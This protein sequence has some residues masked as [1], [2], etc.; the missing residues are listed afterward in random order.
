MSLKAGTKAPEFT[1]KI[2]GKN[3]FK[4]SEQTGKW[5]VLYFYPKDDTPGCTMEA[6]DFRDNMERLTSLGA[7]VVGVSPDSENSH[8]RFKSKYNLNFVL[9]PDSDNEICKLYDILGEKS[10]F[11]KKYI[12][13]I[14][15]TYIISPNGEIAK[16][17]DKVKVQGHVDRI[18]GDLQKLQS[19]ATND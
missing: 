10:M 11:G 12:G 15:T 14:R 2:D 4:L 6:C 7:V 5:V 16:V 3:Q 17:Y 18:I 9:I 8:D 1:S 19:Q 13:V